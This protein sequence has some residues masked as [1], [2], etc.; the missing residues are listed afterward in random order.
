MITK[1]YYKLVVG[2]TNKVLVSNEKSWNYSDPS[3]NNFK[4]R[5]ALR[6]SGGGT[7]QAAARIS[8]NSAGY[9]KYAH[10][11]FNFIEKE[12]NDTCIIIFEFF[13]LD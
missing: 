7:A 12:K 3:G 10:I 1:M 6:I 4:L 2:P 8:L 13:F 5:E 9:K 11:N